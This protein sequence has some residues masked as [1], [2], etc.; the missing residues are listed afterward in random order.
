MY[1]THGSS[2]DAL[3][4]IENSELNE[5]QRGQL[6]QFVSRFPSLTFAKGTTAFLDSVERENRVELPADLKSIIT[7]L[8]LAGEFPEFQVDDYTHWTPRTD[9]P[10]PIWY[11]SDWGYTNDQERRSFLQAGM[12]PVAQWADTGLSTLA[13][14]VTDNRDTRVFEFTGEDIVDDIQ[15]NQ[16]PDSSV[17]PAFNSYTEMLSHITELRLPDNTIIQAH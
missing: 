17:F 8:V 9:N 14:N 10:I 11:A 15:S 2:E 5:E 12:F 16:T 1:L 13:I 3:S 6:N 7:T 4:W